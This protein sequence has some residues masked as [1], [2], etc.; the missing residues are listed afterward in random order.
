MTVEEGE[1]V[2]G[3][4]WCLRAAPDITFDLSHVLPEALGNAGQQTLPLGTVCRGCN[5]YFGT[6]L[7][8]V[9]ARSPADSSVW[10]SCSGS[11]TQATGMPSGTSSLTFRNLQSSL[12]T[13][14]AC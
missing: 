2:D 5:Q 3:C 12:S 7:E 1:T 6:R 11:S 10:R 13:V 14:G 9:Y 8:P 4:I